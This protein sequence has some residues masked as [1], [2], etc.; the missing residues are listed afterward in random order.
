M[1][2]PATIGEVFFVASLNH[3]LARKGERRIQSEAFQA[4]NNL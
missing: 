1:P 2:E 3:R 4:M